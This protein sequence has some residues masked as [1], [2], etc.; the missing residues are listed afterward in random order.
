[1]LADFN[2]AA[3]AYRNKDYAKAFEG[4]GKLAETGDPRAQTVIAMMYK[5]GESVEANPDTAFEWYLRAAA[6]GYAPAQFNVGVMY[7]DGF[8]VATDRTAAIAWLRKAAEAGFERANYKLE[9]MDAEQVLAR[10]PVDADIPWSQSWNFR[11]PNEVRYNAPA[12]QLPGD[13]H[14]YRVQV[15]AMSTEAGALRLWRALAARHPGLFGD[16]QPLIRQS[17]HAGTPVYRVQVGSFDTYA[18]A[19]D[20]CDRL[21]SNEAS[22]GCMPLQQ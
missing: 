6:I 2:T 5:Y 14:V 9:A 3:E 13:P 7:A 12:G 16:R 19:R 17:A 21:Q 1:M 4:F 10:K 20:F 8:G 11:L 22:A 15:G 18:A